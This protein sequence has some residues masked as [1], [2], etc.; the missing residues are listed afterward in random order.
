VG[1]TVGADG[2]GGIAGDTNGVGIEEDGIGACAPGG[3]IPC[4]DGRGAGATDG[5]AGVITGVGVDLAA[6]EIVAGAAP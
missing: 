1:G 4:D 5:I 2:D 3:R 6:G